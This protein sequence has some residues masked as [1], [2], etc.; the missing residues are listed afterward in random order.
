ME[1]DSGSRQEVTPDGTINDGYG[2]GGAGGG[3]AGG[4]GGDGDHGA[5][6]SVV[7]GERVVVG[8]AAGGRSPPVVVVGSR[9]VVITG[10]EWVMTIA[11]AHHHLMASSIFLLSYRS[12]QTFVWYNRSYNRSWEIEGFGV[13]G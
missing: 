7:G 9:M 2:G 11:I 13:V 12:W 4:G 3:G 6:W 8:R 1:R 5:G 10:W